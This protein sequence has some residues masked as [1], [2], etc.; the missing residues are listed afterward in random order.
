MVSIWKSFV[1]FW[2][3]DLK[4][5]NHKNRKG[6]SALDQTK[7]WIF[8][9]GVIQ[10]LDLYPSPCFYCSVQTS[11]ENP[12]WVWDVQWWFQWRRKPWGHR[13]E[14]D[15]TGFF[16]VV[17]PQPPPLYRIRGRSR[18]RVPHGYCSSLIFTSS[19]LS[20]FN[21]YGVFC[22]PCCMY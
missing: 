19:S 17:G 7:A 16:Y 15:P 5:E 8:N 10:S 21:L 18:I 20:S 13:A 2:T 11:P 22:F 1:D 6:I 14:E 12:S 3:S 4:E 9:K